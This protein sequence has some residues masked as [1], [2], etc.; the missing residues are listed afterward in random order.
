LKLVVVIPALDEEAT[1]QRVVE[2]VPRELPGVDRVEVVVVDDGSTDRTADLAAAAGAEVVN[3]PVNLGVG[4]AFRTGIHSALERGADLVVNMDGDGQFDPADIATLAAPVLAGEAG[5][6]TCSRFARRELV[7]KMPWLKKLGNRGMAWIV[8][9]ITAQRFTDVSCGFRC[10]SRDTA[11]RLNLFGRFTYT[12]ESLISLASQGVV[13]RE[14]P[15]AVRGVRE[16]GRS[17]VAHSL[18]RYGVRSLSI[19]LRAVRDHRPLAFFGWMG[20]GAALLGVLCALFVFA[21]WW[22]TGHTSPYRSVLLGS[23]AFGI[24]GVLLGVLAL[25]ADMLGRMRQTNEAILLELRRQRW[26]GSP[27]ED[28]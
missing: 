6:V 18:V 13:M 15:L 22:I 23:A 10:Y 25:L 5:F 21:H 26:P 20:G 19:I 3:H 12:Q 24:V 7:P 28:R 8:N 1:I 2:G 17:R 16:F 4:A 27:S 11:L 9:T 14:V